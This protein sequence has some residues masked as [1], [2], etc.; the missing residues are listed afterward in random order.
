[1][2]QVLRVNGIAE[3]W[4]S[5]S[6]FLDAGSTP[7]TTVANRSNH[8]A[9]TLCTVH[10]GSSPLCTKMRSPL[11]K[12]HLR[13]NGSYSSVVRVGKTPSPS[14]LLAPGT[15]QECFEDIPHCNTSYRSS[16]SSADFIPFAREFKLQR[17]GAVSAVWAVWGYYSR[18]R[19]SKACFAA[20]REVRE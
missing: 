15:Q 10:T 16:G 19:E 17:A 4:E 11:G 14:A 6:Q 9:V 7:T 5:S 13:Q 20:R 3:D 1:V 8:L 18:W 2:T 12:D